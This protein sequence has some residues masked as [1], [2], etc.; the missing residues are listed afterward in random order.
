MRGG[1]KMPSLYTLARWEIV[2]R[3]S[4]FWPSPIRTKLDLFLITGVNFL[5]CT[6]MD[7]FIWLE[8][9]TEQWSA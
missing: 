3:G 2:E 1:V 7:H 4:Y 6:L 9:R 5:A 8:K